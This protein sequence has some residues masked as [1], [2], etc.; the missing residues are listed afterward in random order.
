MDASDMID[1]KPFF[2]PNVK[3]GIAVAKG[4]SKGLGNPGFP[5][6]DATI[7]E[8]DLQPV[9]GGQGKGGKKEE[10]QEN[11]TDRLFPPSHGHDRSIIY[12]VTNK[13]S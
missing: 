1:P 8:P 4:K 12:D 6:D 3:D 7:F 2:H 9:S 11:P 13:R 5:V 10:T